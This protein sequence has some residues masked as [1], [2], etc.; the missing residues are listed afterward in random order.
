MRSIKKSGVTALTAAI[1]LSLGV[2]PAALTVPSIM[3][4]GTATT[5]L[6]P[7]S[8]GTGTK[9]ELST[10]SAQGKVTGNGKT[11]LFTGGQQCAV[12]ALDSVHLLDITGS[13]GATQPTPGTPGFRD[14]DIGVYEVNASSTDPNNASQ[15]F[16]V[17][18]GS[19]TNEESLTV[20]LGDDPG[21]IDAPFGQLLAGSASVGIYAKTQSGQVEV[22]LLDGA[23]KPISA[24]PLKDTTW[25]KT[26]LGSKINLASLSAITDSDGRPFDGI[27]LTALAGSFSL[28]EA[29]FNLVSQADAYMNC[30]D[31]NTY[32]NSEGVK[33]TYT[34]T[35][36]GTACGV[37][38]ITLD[39]A[40]G[41]DGQTTTFHKPL[42]VDPDAQFVFD[43][44]WDKKS[45]ASP[46]TLPKAEI[47]FE[48][49]D[50]E[51][52]WHELGFC[53]DYLYVNG[54]ITGLFPPKKTD[55]TVDTN[56]PTYPTYVA[57]YND[58]R[59]NLDMEKPPASEAGLPGQAGIQFACIGAR[60][61]VFSKAASGFDLQVTDT[62][63]LIGDAQYRF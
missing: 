44:P 56:D 33:V 37:F 57:N 19:F 5:T 16:R 61:P 30:T 9:I 55:G 11:Q 6:T 13:I 23:G 41:T 4:G 46:N 52:V 14:G 7:A 18:Y 49:P 26:K 21:Y 22:T 40:S 29:T 27:R 34:G 24:L 48:I 43:V 35:A 63:Y 31:K 50:R 53:P 51:P 47:D 58:L 60:N 15:C 12:T 25:S 54:V 36:D 28:R 10:T 39:R 59:D 32:T 45:A 42:T 17:D 3:A 8:V 62:L 2:I 20:A 38:G 1:A